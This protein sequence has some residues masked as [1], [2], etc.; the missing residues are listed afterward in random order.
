MAVYNRD[1]LTST[2][3]IITKVTLRSQVCPEMH[4]VEQGESLRCRQ[5]ARLPCLLLRGAPANN[6]GPA[7]VGSAANFRGSCRD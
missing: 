7:G 3:L 5:R 4:C 1:A 6:R 2:Q